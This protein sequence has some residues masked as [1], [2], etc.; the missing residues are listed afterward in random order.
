MKVK[1]YTGN[2]EI[3]SSSTVM[4]YDQKSNLVF[5]VDTNHLKF[6]IELIFADDGTDNKVINRTIDT[7]NNKITLVCNNFNNLF[8]TNTTLPV[9]IAT[10]KGKEMYLHLY[11]SKMEDGIRRVN[12]TIFIER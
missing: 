12:Y 2:H 9:S 11:V 7:M 8:G 1:V 3:I 5:D 6:S 10:I 4:L